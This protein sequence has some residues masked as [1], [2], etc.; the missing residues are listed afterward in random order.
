MMLDLILKN[1]LALIHTYIF[2]WW[3]V[4]LYI[5]IYDDSTDSLE[6]CFRHLTN[7]TPINKFATNTCYGTFVEMFEF[8]NFKDSESL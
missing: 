8:N 3:R 6:V 7:E 2:K 4:K 5:F 1:Y